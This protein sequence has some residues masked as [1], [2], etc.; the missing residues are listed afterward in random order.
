MPN[1]KIERFWPDDIKKNVKELI[2][3]LEQKDFNTAKDF[4]SNI[5]SVLKDKKRDGKSRVSVCFIID[6]LK[7]IDPFIDPM[8][9]ALI[10][11]LKDEQD[12]HVR[13]FS[14]WA[15]GQI[16]QENLNLELVKQTMPIFIGF[17][18]DFSIHVKKF[19]E[20]IKERL[21]AYLEEK[22]NLDQKIQ[23]MLSNLSKLIQE[24]INEMKER[25]KELSKE[26]LAL[27]YR[28][29]YERRTEIEEKIKKFKELNAEAEDE[30]LALRD[31]Y[32][33]EIPSIRGESKDLIQHWR[34]ARG[35]KEVL[36]RR[37]HCILRIQGKIYKIIL[38]IQNK[39]DGKIDINKLKEET[40]YSD[41]EI[42][43]ILKK[44][45]NE[46][47]IPNFMLETLEKELQMKLESKNNQK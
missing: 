3:Y 17:C 8:V 14:V 10:E 23:S 28:S 12:A 1:I 46:E 9:D 39:E 36:I 18:N 42:I 32:A 45:V 22:K 30:I 31:K 13:E 26:A 34:D 35:E 21:D 24:R 5:L 33:N 29:A 41:Q 6:Q 15:L 25:A 40:E 43:E 37:V 44:L 47:I 19:A 20:D 4:L 16:V 11:T 7:G 2:K 38:H 27:D